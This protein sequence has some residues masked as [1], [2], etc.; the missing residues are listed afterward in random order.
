MTPIRE[1]IDIPERVHRDDFVLRLAEGVAQPAETLRTYVVT[2]Q[3][4]DAFDRALGLIEGALASGSSKAAY[5]HGSFGSGKS[6][7][8]A[9]L[10]L[11]LQQQAEARAAEGLEGVV[12]R[13]GDW[14]SGRRFLLAPY[15]MIGK[16]SLD[17]AVLGGYAARV[18]ELHPDAP[19]PG[20]YRSAGLF[21]DARR[22]R[23][24]IGDET[25]FARVNES[26][27][28][29]A[30][31]A[32][33]WG[34][35]SARWDAASFEAALGAP[36]GAEERSRLV[37]ALIDSFFR[38][39]RDVA[40]GSGEAFV[41]L[42]EGLAV[43]A[44]HA[45]DLGYDALVLFLDELILWLATHAADLRFLNE[46]GP[47]VSKLVE[48]E[49]AGRA[50]P[51]VSFVARQRDL[52]ELVGEQVTGAL[53]LGFADVLQWWEARF[54]R[55]T[56]EDRNL[57]EI[58]ARRLLRPRSEAARRQ[59]DDA[60][61]QTG[62][63]RREVFE[64]LLTPRAD[65]AAFRKVYP[66][67]PA[68]VE[69]LVAVSSLL[70]RERTALRV[71]LQILVDGRDT[72]D[73]GEIVPVG[74]LFDAIAE[75]D[76]PFT[77]GARHH[78][79]NARNLYRRKLLPLIEGRHGI[80]KAEAAARPKDDRA[81]R[82]LRADDRL[83]KTLLLSALAPEVDALKNLTAAR[84]AALNHGS[85]RTPIEGREGQE[86]LRRCRAW[87]AEIGEVRIGDDPANPIITLQL[88][89]VDTEGILAGAG[90]HDNA[91]NRRRLIREVLFGALGIENRDELVLY[92][93]AAW[94]GTPRRFEVIF[95]NVRELPDESLATRG[96]ERKVVIDFPFDD[97]GHTPA[98]DLARLN[99]FRGR[100][101]RARTL[102]WLPSF[103]SASAQRDLGTLVR[104]D[105]VLAGERLR[106]FAAHLSPVDQASARELLRNQQ[107]QLR[108][109][110]VH[111]L[112][113][114]YGVENP[115]PGSVD[116]SHP[117]A[118]HFQSLD[119][120][121]E[122]RPPARANLR[123]AMG[124]LFDQMC[125]SQYP[126]HPDFGAPVRT[127]ALRRVHEQVSRAVQEPEGRVAID[128][129]LRPS[130]AQIAVPLRLGEMGETH[131][132]LGRHWFSR[133][134]R[135]DKPLTVAKLRVAMDQPRRMGLPDAAANLVILVYADQANLAFRRHG[136]PWP[137]KLDDLP[138]D[139][140][141]REEA[142]PS[143]EAWTTAAERAGKVFGL[144]VSPLRNAGNVSDL[145]ERLGETAAG[146]GAACD[147]LVERLASLCADLS[148]EDAAAKRL[149]T[150]RAGRALVQSLISLRGRAR[151]EKLAE[152]QPATSLEAMGT[153]IGK[154]GE[155]VDVLE[156]THWQLFAPLARLT[157]DRRG[158]AE[159]LLRKLTEALAADEY[160]VAL[161]GRLPDLANRAANLLAR[162]ATP[163]P[164]PAP[165]TGPEPPAGPGPG[166][167]GTA[168]NLG[169]TSQPAGA[170][171]GPGRGGAVLRE[172]GNGPF[173]GGGA[174]GA[175]G[176]SGAVGPAAGGGTVGSDA[177]GG[178]DGPVGGG[179]AAGAGD[180]AITAQGSRG[181]LDSERLR[182]VTARLDELLRREPG[183]RLAITWKLLR[184]AKDGA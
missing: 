8:M 160:A 30:G 129:P 87:A 108:Q 42:D 163:A 58:A 6:H 90:R 124:S 143:P 154:A 161:G 175:T 85:I 44:R 99:D 112:E 169:L 117:P 64:T 155:V 120:A 71:M 132:V 61:A 19:T 166:G 23:E 157:D 56:L 142:L 105:H 156:R 24:E 110:L 170:G 32:A 41:P 97:P 131:F 179:G 13:H 31:A 183:A 36:A 22:L 14:L 57:P 162:P 151:I 9:V 48:A 115:I 106:D 133:F 4:A 94:R 146:R 78:F 159:G 68:L 116:E 165:G 184:D 176:S 122:P 95:A 37:A 89:A 5:L 137:A 121:F 34:D 1:L 39:Y 26:A 10:H 79:E 46:E 70:Q 92:H 2:P 20:V 75:G 104:I 123:E 29:T 127:A 91:G 96:D 147:A 3:L 49:T 63:V 54:E 98:D 60:Y 118:E 15:H 145:A 33:G 38:G 69:T 50:I 158:D 53:Q 150:A 62:K 86:V 93:D 182:E 174:A 7:F 35:L 77:E 72:L 88:S 125:A 119:P 152:T 114:A 153:S 164:Q 148:V 11:L 40:R 27:A 59:I 111:F 28:S 45:R 167:A 47:K 103:L 177:G 109:R 136:G 16:P 144:T 171:Q 51:I 134:E 138:D 172:G 83:A 140:E 100:D 80:S 12:T 107:S 55:I 168:R 82:A 52:R 65:T 135:L 139:V 67:S 141:L 84:L 17:A 126:A 180:S 73:L 173:E 25:F 81:A 102:V 18:A 181:G 101:A 21:D 149:R 113:G 76:E 128:K 66:F 43:I 74:D 130:M 178:V